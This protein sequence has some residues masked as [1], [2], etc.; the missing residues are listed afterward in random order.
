MITSFGVWKSWPAAP[1]IRSVAVFPFE[2]PGK[3]A[4]SEFLSHG[5]TN[6]LIRKITGLPSLTVK[7]GSS[8]EANKAIDPRVVG[9]HLQVDAIVTGSVSQR[10]G[11]LFVTAELVDMTSGAVLWADRYERN[12]VDVALI[13]DEIA[14]AIVDDGIRLKLSTDDRSRLTRHFTD[15]PEAYKLYMRASYL[16]TKVNEE[17]Y[18]RARDLLLKAVDRDKK[19]ALAYVE[20]SFNYSVMVVD[21]YEPPHQ[22]WPLATD[23]ARKALE[24]DPTLLEAHSRLGAETFFFKRQW[25]SALKDFEIG[26]RSPEGLNHGYT[27]ALWAVGRTAEALR[28]VR[29]DLEQNPLNLDLRLRE[30]DL[31]THLNQTDVAA[32]LYAEIIRDEPS[33][34]RG[35]FGLAEVRRVQERFGDAIDQLRQGLETASG[36]TPLDTSLQ[37]LFARAQGAAGY[38]EVERVIAEIELDNLEIRSARD[39]YVSPLDFGRAHARLGN[40]TQAFDYL[41]AALEDRSPGLMF[42]KVDRAWD[43]VRSDPQFE[44]VVRRVGLP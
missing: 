34:M 38:R 41:N 12:E 35:H 14:S 20:L 4:E 31:L 39:M 33:D 11:K 40:K 23:F 25:K 30:A 13:Q 44:E 37:E 21:G 9:Q 18:L 6:S 3:D 17:D 19:F 32:N 28:V 24:L 29:K 22:G 5:L 26:L 10:S 43:A 27:V 8:H 16:H 15:D 1:R 36:N 2:N 42:L 7:R